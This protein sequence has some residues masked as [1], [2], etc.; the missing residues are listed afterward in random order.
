MDCNSAYQ[1]PESPESSQQMR[2]QRHGI[3]S[4]FQI[5]KT[6]SGENFLY[7]MG[8]DQNEDALRGHQK[9]IYKMVHPCKVQNITKT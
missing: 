9:F 2:L 1:I 7:R 8:L 5:K 6:E 3:T 4:S